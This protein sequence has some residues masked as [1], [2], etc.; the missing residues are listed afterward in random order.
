M[1]NSSGLEDSLDLSTADLCRQHR[2]KL[3]SET[4]WWVLTDSPTATSEQ[5]AY[6][7]ALRDVPA[8]AGFSDSI[9]WPTR[10]T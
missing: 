1:G 2:D 8:Q 6:R 5:L 10:P 4:D 7:Q 3:L 9:S